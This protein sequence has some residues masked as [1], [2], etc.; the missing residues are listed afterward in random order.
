MLEA[1]EDEEL[2]IFNTIF[3]FHGKFND[4]YY[5]VTIKYDTEDH[6]RVIPSF[7]SRKKRKD[8]HTDVILGRRYLS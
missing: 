7:M 6:S 8:S 5:L 4:I 3:G 1:I 2:W